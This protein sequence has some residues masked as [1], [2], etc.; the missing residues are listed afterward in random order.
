M[1]PLV[2]TLE[3]GVKG[4]ITAGIKEARQHLTEFL[5]KV[6]KGEEIIISR[7]KEPIAVIKPIRKKLKK[8]L[9]SHKAL[10]KIISAKGKPLSDMV[11]EYRSD[12]SA[13]A[14]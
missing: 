3:N 1:C 11:S 10:R 6:Q 13:H 7:R 14:G 4:M 2:G 9:E 12:G 8:K 5:S